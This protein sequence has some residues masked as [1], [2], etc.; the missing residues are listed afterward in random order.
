MGAVFTIGA[1]VLKGLATDNT[2]HMALNKPYAQ[3]E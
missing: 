2:L 1:R 3:H